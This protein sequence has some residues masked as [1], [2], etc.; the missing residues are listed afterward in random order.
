MG[1]TTIKESSDAELFSQLSEVKDE[2]FKMRFQHATGQL[3]NTAL[4]PNLKKKVAR[5]ETEIR[6]RE[7]QAAESSNSV[8]GES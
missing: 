2:M 6:M 3:E 1:K 7:I 4:I 5:I 8:Q